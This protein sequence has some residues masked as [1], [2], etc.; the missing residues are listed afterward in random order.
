[1]T[2]VQNAA[3]AQINGFET[4][5]EWASTNDFLLTGGLTYLHAVT[6]QNYCGPGTS[7][8]PNYIPGTAALIKDARP[9][10]ITIR[11]VRNLCLRG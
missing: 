5:V 11:K 3:S 9:A 7:A 2:V 1:M 4:D 10:Q 6:R 8:N